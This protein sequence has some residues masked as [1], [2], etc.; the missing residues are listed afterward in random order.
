MQPSAQVVGVNLCCC[1]QVTLPDTVAVAASG[2]GGAAAPIRTL[3]DFVAWAVAAESTANGSP[4]FLL[5]ELPS[6]G[7]AARCMQ[8]QSLDQS[9]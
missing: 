3:L 9:A 2:H 5:D 7:E 1:H 6:L 8:V 4:T